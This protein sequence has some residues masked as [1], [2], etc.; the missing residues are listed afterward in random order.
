[1][2]RAGSLGEDG[3]ACQSVVDC[4]VVGYGDSDSAEHTARNPFRAALSQ[5]K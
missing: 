3:F 1:M 4:D 2:M 5:N